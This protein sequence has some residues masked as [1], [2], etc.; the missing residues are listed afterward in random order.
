MFF[1]PTQTI[2]IL[3][4]FAVAQLTF[5]AIVL[6]QDLLGLGQHFFLIDV[7]FP[8]ENVIGLNLF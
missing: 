1:S 6:H 3:Y 8:D 2:L 4:A 5:L 7:F